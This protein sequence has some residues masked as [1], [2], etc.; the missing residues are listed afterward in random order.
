MLNQIGGQLHIETATYSLVILVV[1]APD[2]QKYV[3]LIAHW[4]FVV[5]EKNYSLD[6]MAGED[7]NKFGYFHCAVHLL[8][9]K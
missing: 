2:P 7:E 3:N 6:C 8:V 1:D 5:H 4:K 9:E